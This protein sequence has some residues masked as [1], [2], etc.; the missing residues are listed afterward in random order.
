MVARAQLQAW[1]RLA[2]TP[3]P[4]PYAQEQSKTPGMGGSP[5]PEH[6]EFRELVHDAVFGRGVL[7]SP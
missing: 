6:A 5:T 2:L 7:P 1:C 4:L 3:A